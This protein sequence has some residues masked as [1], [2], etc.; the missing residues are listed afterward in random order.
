LLSSS[1]TKLASAT[2]K[3][4]GA[5]EAARQTAKE[6]AQYNSDL[7]KQM[8]TCSNNYIQFETELCA[9]KK[10]RGELYKMKSAG[11]SAFFSRIARLGIGSLKSAPR[12]APGEN[13]S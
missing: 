5:G 11:H 12:S 10:I 3:E 13:R 9:L 4:A 6:N 7:V 8:K 2:E 1:Q